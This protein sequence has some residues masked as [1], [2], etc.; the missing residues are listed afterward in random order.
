MDRRDYLDYWAGARE[1]VKSFAARD[2]RRIIFGACTRGYG[3]E[4][5]ILPTIPEADLIAFE[6]KTGLTLPLEYRTFLEAY[7]AGG[8]GPSYGLYD[9]RDERFRMDLSTP[10]PATEDVWGPDEECPEEEPVWKLPGLVYICNHGCGAESLIELNGPDP[11]RIWTEWA[12]GVRRG[13]RFFDFYREWLDNSEA[14]LDQYRLLQS[15][16]NREPPLDPDR[17]VTLDDIVGILGAD[18]RSIEGKDR[19]GNPDGNR[20]L[21]FGRPSVGAVVVDQDN[22]LVEIRIGGPV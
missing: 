20:L 19:N 4:Y 16:A 11:G 13:E 18:Y 17:A 10:F 21:Y 9:F 2:D 12:E 5:K 22:D 15:I 8:A 7:G 6:R 3:H 1:T 14:A